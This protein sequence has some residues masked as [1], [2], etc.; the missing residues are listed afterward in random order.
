MLYWQLFWTFLKIGALSFGGGMA[1]LPLIQQE[2]AATGWMTAAE[3]SDIVAISQMTPGPLAIN[4]ATFAG[5]R[6]GGVL[7]AVAATVGVTLPSLLLSL[8]AARFFFAVRDS[9]LVRAGMT[10]IRPAV[11]GMV[12]ATALNMLFL[13]VAGSELPNLLG[14][15]PVRFSAFGLLLAVL[16][17]LLLWRKVSP[18]LLI[19]LSGAAGVLRYVVIQKL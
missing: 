8:L 10:G 7:G 4:A 14:G 11:A 1:M 15:A 17:F 13:T 19:I 6:A 2:M 5:T 9:K 3:V 18:V 12:G 16:T